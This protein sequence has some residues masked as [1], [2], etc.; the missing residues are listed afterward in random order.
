[1]H[2]YDFLSPAFF[3]FVMTEWDEGSGRAIEHFEEAFRHCDRPCI[4]A[5]HETLLML[6]VGA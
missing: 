5:Y 2:M 1:M 3:P 4:E 6:E